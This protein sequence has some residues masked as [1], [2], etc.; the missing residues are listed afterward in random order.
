METHTTETSPDRT[1]VSAYSCQQA[2]RDRARRGSQGDTIDISPPPRPTTSRL[3]S[4][5]DDHPYCLE[6]FVEEAAHKPKRDTVLYLA[7]GSNL[8]SEKFRKDRGIKPLSQINVLVPSLRMTFDLPGIPYAEPCFANSARRDPHDD[9]SHSNSDDEKTSLLP[10]KDGN[11]GYLDGWHKGLIGVVY[12]VTPEDY[13]HIIATEGGGS[14]YQDILVE[15]HPFANAD[16][17]EAVPKHPTLPPFKAHTLFAPAV[18]DG[19][20][21]KKGG[22]LQR[23]RADYAQASARYLKLITDGAEE[24]KLPYEYQEYLLSLQPYTITTTKQ[25]LGQFVIL[26]TW[27]PIVLSMFA[28]GKLVA[29]KNGRAPKWMR[30][31]TNAVFKAVWKSYDG[32]FQPLFGDGERTIEKGG[33]EDSQSEGRRGKSMIRQRSQDS[34]SDVEK[35]I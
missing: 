22:H 25:R 17:R 5:R 33:N 20:P 18:P 11:G 26:A 8:S 23:P 7:Y 29:G 34:H 14:G 19:E 16:P 10:S 3:E 2:L 6:Q 30:E 31:L 13:A 35:G 24:C 28:L 12:E 9:I 32:F 15:C 21:P 27:L 1:T 4:S